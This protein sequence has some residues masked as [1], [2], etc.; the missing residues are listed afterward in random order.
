MKTVLNAV[1]Q[2]EDE[3]AEG[4]EIADPAETITRL[5]EEAKA[6]YDRFLRVSAEFENY[7]KRSAREA[8]DFR[9]YANESLLKDLLPVIDNLER[10]LESSD[11]TAATLAEGVGLTRKEILKV[12]ERYGATPVEAFGS[13]FDPCRHQALMMDESGQHPPNTVVKE[14][15]KGYML[16]DRLLRPALVAVSA[17]TA[18]ARQCEEAVNDPAD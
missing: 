5:E 13:E 4:A 2:P 1:Q 17:A 10:A 7:K 3:I 8:E 18:E 11:A 16:K 6:N 9:K 15:Q 12:L 14:L